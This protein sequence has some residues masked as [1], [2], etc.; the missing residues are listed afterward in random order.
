[1]RITIYNL[2]GQKV[3]TLVDEYQDA[4]YRLINWDGKED[5]GK[6][7]ATGIYF[8]QIKAGNLS[9]VKKMVLLQ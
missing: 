1:M 9:T 2:L 7:A 3:R 6:Q 8:Y 4:G 5:Q